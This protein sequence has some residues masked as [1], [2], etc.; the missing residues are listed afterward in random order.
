MADEPPD[1]SIGG[2]SIMGSLTSLPPLPTATADGFMPMIGDHQEGDAEYD[3][4]LTAFTGMTGQDTVLDVQDSEVLA[5]CDGA[6]IL[7]DD[8]RDSS[9]RISMFQKVAANAHLHLGKPKPAPPKLDWVPGRWFAY[10]S[11]FRI[12]FNC[13]RVW[14]RPD[15]GVSEEEIQEVLQHLTSHH[16]WLIK[17]V[18]SK[19]SRLA[20]MGK[21]SFRLNEEEWKP[22]ICSFI[23]KLVAFES[24]LPRVGMMHNKNQDAFFKQFLN[25]WKHRSTGYNLQ[26]GAHLKTGHIFMVCWS[27]FLN[28]IN[29]GS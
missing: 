12:F 28:I 14:A 23:E 2:T 25:N 5:L 11:P 24:Y 18:I 4:T 1:Q 7:D 19:S 17:T 15:G 8:S 22:A 16:C 26:R 20:S 21:E 27:S 10:A 29:L 6:S 3:E 9:S 13:Y